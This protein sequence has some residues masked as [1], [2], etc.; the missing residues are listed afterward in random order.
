M[1]F[2]QGDSECKNQIQRLH[3]NETDPV[4]R[5]TRKLETSYSSDRVASKARPLQIK[6]AK[7]TILLTILKVNHEYTALGT[8]LNS[9]VEL[10]NFF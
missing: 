8:S 9:V 5:K 3:Y 7:V 2:F 4:S 10:Y 6:Q 1:A